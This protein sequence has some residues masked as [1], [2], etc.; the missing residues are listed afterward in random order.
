MV[1]FL[2]KSLDGPAKKFNFVVVAVNQILR[3][4]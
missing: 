2:R 3:I 1:G 4:R